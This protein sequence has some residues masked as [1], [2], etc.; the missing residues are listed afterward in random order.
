MGSGTL[1]RPG[2]DIC[3]GSASSHVYRVK[4]FEMG[5]GKLYDP[6]ARQASQLWPCEEM[7][8]SLTRVILENHSNYKEITNLII[9]L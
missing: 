9:I 7:M 8:S 5:V 2:T 3:G 6:S 4:A 1:Q